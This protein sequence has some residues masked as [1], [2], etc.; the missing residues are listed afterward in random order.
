MQHLAA[1]GD[2][3]AHDAGLGDIRVLR[4]ERELCLLD[5]DGR[6]SR[7]ARDGCGGGPGGLGTGA[8]G[9]RAAALLHAATPV[10]LTTRSE[11]QRKGEGNG[12]GDYRVDGGVVRLHG[13][14]LP[15]LA[16]R[17]EVCWSTFRP[18][19]FGVW[20]WQFGQRKTR[21]SRRLSL[22]SPLAW[23][24]AIDSRLPCHSSMPHSSHRFSFSPALRRRDLRCVR[25]VRRPLTR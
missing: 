15:R 2:L 25:L 23:C 1:V 14:R 5:L 10:V 11:G 8:R 20:L 3:E 4:I 19:K 13:E 6:Y 9:G 22:P 17:Q 24:S 16:R 21:F 18:A 7:A 12:K